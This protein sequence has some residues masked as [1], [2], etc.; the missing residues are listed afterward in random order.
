M[1]SILQVHVAVPGSVS[2]Q[3]VVVLSQNPVSHALRA[4]FSGKKVIFTNVCF[5]LM[6]ETVKLFNIYAGKQVKR[7]LR[8]TSE[9]F[10]IRYL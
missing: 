1:Y 9:S 6:L 3:I 7:S 5:I 2:L 10:V 8:H 4:V